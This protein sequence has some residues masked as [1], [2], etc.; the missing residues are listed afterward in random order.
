[1]HFKSGNLQSV[2]IV[3][4]PLTESPSV[5]G[6]IFPSSRGNPSFSTPSFFVTHSSLNLSTE[7]GFASSYNLI[8][9][10]CS[11][12]VFPDSGSTLPKLGSVFP[13]SGSILPESGP[14]FL[15]TDSC[16]P[17][18]I[19]LHLVA[20]LISLAPAFLCFS[21]HTCAQPN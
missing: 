13:N 6:L 3:S 1:M 14:V 9:Q 15:I 11:S 5:I 7:V 18:S 2:Q 8:S 12:S 21:V 17:E 10:P 20:D 4:P 16:Y 19:F